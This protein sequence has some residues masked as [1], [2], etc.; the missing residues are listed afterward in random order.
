MSS[1]SPTEAQKPAIYDR[2][3]DILVSASAGSGK[4][5]VLVNRVIQELI[6]DDQLYVDQLLLLTFTRAAAKNMRERIRK[7][8]EASQHP[9]FMKDAPDAERRHAIQRLRPQINRLAMTDISTIDG[10]CQRLIKRYY[11][12]IGL[13]PQ[14]RMSNDAEQQLLKDQVYNQLE[15]QGMDG[16]L[17]GVTKEQFAKLAANFADPTS[18]VGEGLQEVVEALY[19]KSDAQA[20]PD[21]WLDQLNH[22][23]DLPT[24]QDVTASH[25]YRDTLQ[26]LMAE[27]I[28]QALDDMTRAVEI[29]EAL[30]LEEQAE[31][32]GQEKDQLQAM[33]KQV[34]T[35]SWDKLQALIKADIFKRLP[36][37]SRNTADNDKERYKDAQALRKEAKGIIKQ[38]ADDY[39]Q[40]DN[41]QMIKLSRAAGELVKQL[42]A[43]VKQFRQQ[44]QQEKQRRQ[45]LDYSDLE[46]Y[47]YQILNDKSTTGRAVLHDLQQHYH[48]ILVDEYQDTNQLQDA[49][50]TRLHDRSVN[51]LFLVGDVKQSIYGFRQA[52]PTLFQ[53]K[54]EKFDQAPDEQAE[55][56]NLADNF[57][58]LE[59]VIDFTN[60]I[61][62][63]VMS[64]QLGDDDYDQ[65]AQLKYNAKW[66]LEEHDTQHQAPAATELL[67][68]DAN[69]DDQADGDKN[70]PNTHEDD[71]QTGEIRM[72][73]MRIRQLLDDEHE[74]VYDEENNEMRRIRPGDI[75]ILERQR[76]I[77]NQLLQEFSQLNIPVT[78]HDV[79]NYF[80]ATEVRVMLSV[81]RIID[82]SY[83]DIP[84]VAVLRS[85]IVAVTDPE[86]ALIRLAD[87]DHTY[88]DAMQKFLAQRPTKKQVNSYGVNRERL[89][90]KISQFMGQLAK[91]QRIAAR[92]PLVDLIWQIYESTG[93]MDYVTAM[94]NGEQRRANLH[95]LYERAK[96]YEDSGLKGLYQFIHFIERMQKQDQDLGVAPVETNKNTVN[97]LTIHE[98]K[99]LEYPIVLLIDS[100]RNFNTRDASAMARFVINPHQVG[101]GEDKEDRPSLGIQ[102]IG[103]APAANDGENS[104]QDGSPL[105]L[106]YMLPQYQSAMRLQKQAGLAEEMR[107]LYV[108]LTRAKQRLIITGSVNESR[109]RRGLHQLWQKWLQTGQGTETKL[110]VEQ[111]LSN[112]S[113]LQW[114]GAALIRTGKVDPATLGEEDEGL[115]SLKDLSSADFK[116][117]VYDAGQLAQIEKQ[118]NQQP[119]AKGDL[120][121]GP[122]L[123][124]K[125]QE[126]IAR[127]IKM[128]YPHETA[129][130]TT[131]FQTVSAIRE[132]FNNQD[133]DDAQMGRLTFDR[134]LVR[135]EGQYQVKDDFVR[136]QFMAS[137][138]GKPP[139]SVVGTATHLIF[140]KL[141]LNRGQVTFADINELVDDL[142]A[143]KLIPS[144]AVANAID[145]SGIAAFYQTPLGQALLS[146]PDQVHREQPFSMLMKG[147]QLFTGLRKEKEDGQVLIH[148]IIDGFLLN[149]DGISLFDYKTDWLSKNDYYRRQEL[150]NRYQ[151]QVNLYAAALSSWIDK[152]IKHRYLYFVKT[153]ELY[154]ITG[155]NS[156]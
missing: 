142:T 54:Q 79:K 120:L 4:T 96:V 37:I 143:K 43:V 146:K 63:Q 151:G 99:G 5:A 83:Q 17:T 153:H 92:H 145:R 13:D 103:P 47:A 104:Q 122:V 56:I 65:S 26:P 111:L 73:A 89:V 98:S 33:Q 64:K 112:K 42:V 74:Q 138:E 86:L 31:Q 69:A 30:G 102:Y 22:D 15:N 140:Q 76:G 77:N 109:S 147:S 8:L 46:H 150:I 133:P 50:V 121:Q 116:L 60:L 93:Y 134:Q 59:N 55:T 67:I 141:D 36:S 128:S 155:E 40:L 71:K 144:T 100:N 154:E 21:L 124:A 129:E 85:P 66:Y 14:Y 97:V 82:N 106:K 105:L 94:P 75:A 49:I 34:N 29:T 11:Y 78:V 107:L 72:A 118:L 114:I 32:M 88:Y 16:K 137:Q 113:F 6:D 90:E 35:A 45:V 95:A 24:G 152:P 7:A 52:D 108:A 62:K 156:Q 1:F 57:R 41:R 2:H 125:E 131:A 25:Y 123:G 44:Y 139:A 9:D 38:L 3:R 48:E 91:W 110:P 51:N 58:S 148:G 18:N 101:H 19:E 23:Y 119:E 68:Y 12:I 117:Q 10:F 53:H 20:E 80:Q 130:R 136:P 127:V 115:N 149:D 81:L 61:F 39:L 70:L 132:L 28:Q 27:T 84:L 87:R 135:S 126:K